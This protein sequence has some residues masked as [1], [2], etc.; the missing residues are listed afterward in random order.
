MQDYSSELGHRVATTTTPMTRA[1]YAS[2][3]GDELAEPLLEELEATSMDSSD[4]QQ[5]KDRL[6]LLGNVRLPRCALRRV[7]PRRLGG[8]RASDDG[9]TTA[10]PVYL[11]LAC[12]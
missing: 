9:R 6:P 2:T 12:L 7:Q 8:H 4:E 3:T 5:A 1:L 10:G 11:R